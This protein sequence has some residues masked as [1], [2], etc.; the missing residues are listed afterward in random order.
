MKD[1]VPK[2]G[3]GIAVIGQID[4]ERGRPWAQGH[5]LYPGTKQLSRDCGT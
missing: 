2:D 5:L 1:S 3:R 4:F